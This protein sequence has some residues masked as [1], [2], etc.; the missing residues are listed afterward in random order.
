[1][2]DGWWK[3]TFTGEEP[4]DIDLEHVAGLIK[5]GYTEGEIVHEHDEET[6]NDGTKN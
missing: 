6:K 4:N 5:E 1:M 3:I 2:V